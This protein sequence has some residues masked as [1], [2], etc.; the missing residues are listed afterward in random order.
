MLVM[1]MRV[2]T[3]DAENVEKVEALGT[4]GCAEMQGCFI[5]WPMLPEQVTEWWFR[6]VMQHGFSF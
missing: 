4:V 2:S 6:R 3:E 1:E 5:A